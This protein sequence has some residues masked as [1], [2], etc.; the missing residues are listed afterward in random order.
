MLRDPVKRIISQFHF[1]KREFDYCRDDELISW[2]DSLTTFEFNMQTAALC[3]SPQPVVNSKHLEMAKA[4]LHHFD[5]IGFVEEYE[6]A[7]SLFD[8]VYGIAC[9]ASAVRMN[10]SPA[11][12]N[13][14]DALIENLRHRCRFDVELIEYAKRLNIAKVTALEMLDGDDLEKMPPTIAKLLGRS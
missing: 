12:S 11:A 13:V 6:A 14:S 5:F 7:L 8:R 9:S 2:L 3:G 4:N 10:A 1:Q